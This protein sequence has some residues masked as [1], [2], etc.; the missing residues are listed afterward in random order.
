[1]GNERTMNDGA[2]WPLGVSLIEEEAVYNFAIYSKDAQEVSLLLYDEQNFLTPL[3]IIPF[4]VRS[5]KMGRVWHKCVPLHM[6]M[7][8][9]YYAYRIDGQNTPRSGT[10]FDP[11]KI[12]LDPY[13]RGIFFPPGHSRIAACLPGSNAGRAP[14]GILPP[15]NPPAGKP[16]PRVARHSH[17]LII[18][19]MHVRGFTRQAN[20]GVTHGKRG[21]YA[22]V[23]AKI[24]YLQQLGITAVELMPIQQFDPAEENYWGYNTL[25]FFSPHAQY[26]SNTE[27]G[28][29]LDEFRSMVEA[30]HKA[31]IEVILDAVYNHTTEGGCKGPTYC[32][33]G[34][35]NSTY[36][37]LDPKDMCTYI[38]HSGCENDLRTSHPVVRQLVIDS[39]RY[40]VRE[41]NVDGFRFDL[42]SVFA[43]ADDGSLNLKD[44]PII[45]EITNDPDLMNVRLIAEPWA[46]DGSAYI[47]GRA[48]PG[49]TWQ[50]WNDRYRNTLRSFVKG[51]GNLVKDLMTRLYGSTDLFPDDLSNS[52]KRLQSVNFVDCHDGPD[53]CDLVSYTNDQHKSWNCG[54]EG[55]SGAPPEVLR[56]RQQQVK[57]FCCLLMLS[58]GVPMFVAGDEFMNTQNGNENP[59]DQDNETTW[60]D[61]SLTNANADVLRFFKMMIA[62]RKIHSSI[63]RDA[64]WREDVTWYGALSKPDLSPTSHT[65]AFYLD[66]DTVADADLY[67]M[68]N[69]YWQDVEFLIQEAGDWRRIVDTSLNSP[70]DITTERDAPTITGTTYRV[71]ARSVVVLLSA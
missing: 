18:Y 54:F 23:I 64:G 31:G 4:D 16:A 21:T 24:P 1:M 71:T 55:V 25:N 10:R 22:G 39:L 65:L 45:S 12:L 60:L 20:S 28:G 53:M 47:L 3:A 36:Y 42:A 32:Y 26:S 11:Q 33:R 19:E 2:P 69:S 67:V 66:G 51:D 30:L 27:P 6:A 34:I 44:P 37:A 17:D 52:C 58:N 57:N 62:F 48:F 5:N 41:T 40:W 9:V 59:Y 29:P 50:Q 68:I 14:L 13:A 56:L 7:K 8:A 63:G 61:W 43:F 15:H 46:A 38:N 35:D 70:L 49:K